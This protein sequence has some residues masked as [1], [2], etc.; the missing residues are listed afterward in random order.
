MQTRRHLHF[1]RFV[2]LSLLAA[3]CAVTPLRAQVPPQDFDDEDEK[4][5]STL[6]LSVTLRRLEWLDRRACTRRDAAHIRGPF[7]LGSWIPVSSLRPHLLLGRGNT[8]RLAPRPN[9]LDQA[10]PWHA[11][12]A[13]LAPSTLRGATWNDP[14][15]GFSVWPARLLKHG[16]RSAREQKDS[17]ASCLSGTPHR[18]VPG[19]SLNRWTASRRPNSAV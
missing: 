12:F 8:V 6:S 19:L 10:R 15:A 3:A 11:E 16:S 7:P 17:S 2:A 4:S 13:S 18:P 1:H 9:H 5:A 14:P